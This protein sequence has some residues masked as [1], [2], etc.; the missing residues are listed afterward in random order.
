MSKS[1]SQ[2]KQS[3]NLY[4]LEKTLV[5]PKQDRKRKST[6]KNVQR[7]VFKQADVDEQSL[8]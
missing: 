1:P 6:V 4:M 2:A 3:Q 8:K 7:S 5:R